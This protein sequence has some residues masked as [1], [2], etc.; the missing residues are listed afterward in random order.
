MNPLISGEISSQSIA[1]V[2][3]LK[4]R[5]TDAATETMPPHSCKTFP[6]MA[7]NICFQR[8]QLP[9]IDWIFFL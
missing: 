9:K 7:V 1:D 2:P 4:T 5:H 6:I 3:S 8:Q